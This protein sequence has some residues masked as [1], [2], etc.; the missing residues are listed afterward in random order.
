M[1]TIHEEIAAA[2]QRLHDLG[3]PVVEAALDARLLAQHALGWD[4]ATLLASGLD[5]ASPAFIEHFSAMLARRAAHEPLAYIVGTKDFWTLTLDVSP[6]VLIPRPETEILVEEALERMPRPGHGIR[7]ADVCT[8][9]GCVAIALATERPGVQIVATDISDQALAVAARNAAKYRAA[10]RVRFLRTDM[11]SGVTEM[12]D[13][14]VSNPPYVRL[15]DR[16]GLPPEVCDFEP[17]IALFGGDDGL[18]VARSLAAHAIVRLKPGGLLL[19]ECGAGQASGVEELIQD[20]S[21]LRM[22]EIRRDLQGIPRVA[23]AQLPGRSNH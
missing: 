8:G 4:A 3:S 2:R 19:F 1:S 11:L 23:I 21:P 10:D 6:H 15:A 20:A 12:F 17:A 22:L 9:S 16:S 14:I 18:D 13:V 7:V 5:T